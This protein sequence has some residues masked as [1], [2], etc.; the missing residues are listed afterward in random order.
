[1][2]DPFRAWGLLDCAATLAELGVPVFPLQPGSKQPHPGSSGCKD[3]TTDLARVERWWDAHPGD[4]IGLATGHGLD[5]LDVDCKNGQPGYDTLRRALPL[6]PAPAVTVRTPTGGLHLWYASNGEGNHA[7]LA[8]LDYRGAGGYVLAPGSR[9]RDGLYEWGQW[10]PPPPARAPAWNVLQ[11]SLSPQR[12]PATQLPARAGSGGL[13]ALQ[14]HVA[15]LTEG[16]RN[17]GLYWAAKRAVTEG[18]NPDELRDPA[19][20]AG[21]PDHEITATIN[22]ARRE[23]PQ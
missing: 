3:A 23:T 12:R 17:A 4:N 21:L 20:A 19:R 16:N 8:G 11:A 15:A 1:M 18:H 5:V 9:T 10:A 22:S 14:R 6:L 2:P 13:E 7:G